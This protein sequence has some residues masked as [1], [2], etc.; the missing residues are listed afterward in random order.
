MTKGKVYSHLKDKKNDFLNLF[1]IHH[2]Q[3]ASCVLGKLISWVIINHIYISR[4]ANMFLKLMTI[5]MKKKH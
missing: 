4:L 1:G 2:Q 3:V 5:A